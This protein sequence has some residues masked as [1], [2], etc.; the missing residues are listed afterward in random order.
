MTLLALAAACL[1][2]LAWRE[3]TNRRR[4]EQALVLFARV[5]WPPYAKGHADGLT[6]GYARGRR[7]L[8]SAM[9]RARLHGI[10]ETLADMEEARWEVLN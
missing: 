6:D 3:H 7:D 1:A 10:G 5:M 9:E 8:R 2:V 4:A